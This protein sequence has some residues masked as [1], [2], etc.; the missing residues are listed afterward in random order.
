MSIV[1]MKKCPRCGVL[2]GCD[3]FCESCSAPLGFVKKT[4]FNVFKK[5]P[6]CGHHNST[7][8][9]KCSDCSSD[10]SSVAESYE[11][12]PE[13]INS[14]SSKAYTNTPFSPVPSSSVSHAGTRLSVVLAVVVGV[15]GFIGGIV[16]GNVF[17]VIDQGYYYTS[18]EFNT[19]LMLTIWVCTVISVFTLV[20]MYHH[21]KNQEITNEFLEKISNNITKK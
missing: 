11:P 2:N 5:C 9:T 10:I 4:Y 12:L 1:L 7:D 6:E 21:F 20:L 13:Q 19:G 3:D 17:P 8:S 18:E 16:C 15:L 14:S